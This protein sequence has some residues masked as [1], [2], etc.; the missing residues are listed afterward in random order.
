MTF[1]HAL[2]TNNYGPS[3]FI[4]DASAAN[5]THTTLPSALASASS[6]DTISI[7]PGTYTGNFSLKG[8]VNITAFGSDSSLNGTG[9]VII[10]G[11]CT[12]SEAGTVTISGVQLQTNSAAALAVTGSA[13]S[14]VNLQNCYLNFTNNTGITYSSSNSSS[15]INI[16]NCSGDLGTT[17]I[18]I[19]TASS[20]G[21]MSLRYVNFNNS[22]G[23]TTASATSSTT[24][25]IFYS[26]FGS[27]FSTS[28]TGN[29]LFENTYVDA[30]PIN[31]ACFT[32]AG[33]GI[34]TILGGYFAS[35][36]ASCLS[37]GSGT[38]C[39]IAGAILSSSNTNVIT[40]AG[41]SNYRT[42]S[43]TGS[44][45]TINTTTQ[46]I[47][48][49]IAG[50]TTTAPT[51]GY[52]GES[53]TANGTNVSIPASGNTINVTSISLTAG[54]WDV[55]ALSN[56][57]CPGAVTILSAG[58]STTSATLGLT[59]GDN[60]ANYTAAFSGA[61]IPMAIPQKRFTLTSTTTVY[62]CASA[63]FSTGAVNVYGRLSATRVG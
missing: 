9:K 34:Q 53:I 22:G 16:Q 14:V 1:T 23:S 62:L 29:I 61:Q 7:R 48:G 51:A 57:V 24:I 18:G 58:I 31:T 25:E 2:S 39:N 32:S 54:I 11:T 38:T 12:L 44:S 13:A 45:K 8:G 40:G 26:I 46:T 56:F 15:A 55:S 28:S 43:F 27:V 10:Q 6:G 3:K 36:T 42:L 49:T 52:L 20:A 17:G 50:S 21:R 5:G 47:A 33:T 59:I 37:I 30:S 63:T 35:G 19:F 60:Q 4:V 41:T